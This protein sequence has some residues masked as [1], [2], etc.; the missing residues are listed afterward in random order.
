MNAER[1]IKHFDRIAEAPGAVPRLRRFVLDFA[2]GGRLCPQDKK[3]DPGRLLLDRLRDER[4]RYAP[5]RKGKNSPAIAQIHNEPSPIP[6]T[7]AWVTIGDLLH[8]DSQNG[9]SRKPDDAP[10]GIPILRISAATTRADGIIAEEQHKLI[11]RVPAATQEQLILEDGDLLACR[12]NGNR[13]FVGRLALYE[14]HLGLRMI[15]P[16]KLIRLRLLRDFAVPKLVR[17][18]GESRLVRSE[19]EAYAATTVGNWG[20]SAGNLKKVRLPL[21]PLAEQRRIV[22]KVDELMTLC[23]RLEAQLALFE[24]ESGRFLEAVLR[25][26]LADDDATRSGPSSSTGSG[27]IASRGR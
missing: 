1:L 19:I 13:G 4:R 23:D 16:D 20:I 8:G 26:V 6:S 22:A 21:P 12:F 9:Y 5:Q 7:W 2:V 18:F 14:G 11:G 17:Y 10:D 25:E 3:D 15:Y 24:R 27:E